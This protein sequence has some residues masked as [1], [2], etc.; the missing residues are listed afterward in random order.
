M[1]CPSFAKVNKDTEDFI[2]F[3]GIYSLFYAFEEFLYL[4]DSLKYFGLMD[5]S[6]LIER[7]FL[8]KDSRDFLTRRLNRYFNLWLRDFVN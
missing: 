6:Y 5:F 1:G 4:R 3:E 7:D 2:Q 8:N